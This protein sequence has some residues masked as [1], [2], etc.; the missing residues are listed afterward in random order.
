[1]CREKGGERT[2]SQPYTK[3]LNAHQLHVKVHDTEDRH[4][5]MSIGGITDLARGAKRELC[6]MVL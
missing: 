4:M 1:M 2:C 5:R 3:P 6:D